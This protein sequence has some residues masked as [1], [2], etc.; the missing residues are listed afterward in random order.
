MEAFLI[1]RARRHWQVLSTVFLGVL[2]STGLLASC[3]LIVKTVMDFAL[4]HKLRSSL[5]ENGTIF[6]NSSQNTDL[7]TY[8]EFD[9]NIKEILSLNV[10][11]FSEQI[12]TIGTPWV[13]PWQDEIQ[14]VDERI[15][16]R[17]YGE[18]EDQISFISGNWPEDVIVK[19]N[20]IRAVIFE[21]MANT[22]GLEIG[23]RLPVS[24]KF[25]EVQPSI[26]IEVSGIVQPKNA[27]DPYWIIRSNPLKPN[28]NPRYIA[29]HNALLTERDLFEV[30]SSLFPNS[31]L[32][33]NWLAVLDPN[34]IQSE[35]VTGIITGVS[36]A[37]T[38]IASLENRVTIDT[39]IENYL[40][41]FNSQASSVRAP[42]YLLVGEVLFLAL[43]Y[44]IMVAA[45]S[46]RQVEGEFSILASRGASISQL[47]RVQV[48]EAFLICFVAL[49][50]GP[51][52]AYALVWFLGKIGPISDVNQIDWIARLPDASWIAAVICVS[53]CF[54]ALM[55]P[56]IPALKSSVVEHRRSITR[57]TDIPLWQRYYIDV[58][59][60]V[61]GLVALWRLSLYGSI[62]E[63][64][65]GGIDWLLL[66]A[67]LAL[68]IGSATILL[69]LFPVIFRILSKLTARSRGLTIPLAFWQTS[70]DPT[71][72][73][74]LILLFTLA[75]ALGILSTGLN[76][77]LNSSEKERARY[78]TGGEVRI[79][80][81]NFIPLSSIQSNS[82]V[83]SAS[84]V[85]RGNGSS[86]V[87]SYR[88][89]PGFTILAVDPFSFATVTQ[90]RTDF[91]E[92]YIGFVL[93]KLI[94]EPAQLPVTTIPLSGKPSRIGIWVTEPYPARTE[95]VLMDYLSIKAKIQSSEG[96][97]IKIDFTLEPLDDVFEDKSGE[98]LVPSIELPRWRYFE[99]ILPSFVE[100]GYPLSLHSLWFKIYP[101]SIDSGV[102][103]P[104]G[105]LVI[106]DMTT[107][108][109]Q[110]LSRTIEDFENPSNIWQT[111]DLQSVASITKRDITHS[112]LASMRL[113]LRTTGSTNWTVL[114]PA[115]TLRKE[116]I[117]VLSSSTFLEMTG[118]EVGD[119]F[120]ALTSGV[121]LLFK[122]RDKVNYFPTMYETGDRGYIITS[123]EAILAELNKNSRYPVNVNE[124]WFTVESHQ[125]I[126]ALLENYPQ[127][128]DSKDIESERILYKSNPLTLGLRSVIFLGYSLT[129]LLSLV[130][131]TTFFYLSARQRESIYGMLRSLGLSTKQLYASLVIEQLIL[132]IAGLALGVFLGAM[133]N[134][135]NLPGLPISF[136]DAPP[137][138]PFIPREDW[139]AVAQLGLILI[140]SFVLT[141]GIGTYLLWRTKLHQVLR[142]GEE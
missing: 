72:V 114:S 58:F 119:K 52:L 32:E 105:P 84:A 77:T 63:S 87:R 80:S 3:P 36:I 31:H 129:L 25:N 83:T 34:H 1:N 33:L 62:A 41:Q 6:L 124:T 138:P 85:W 50:C 57:R 64:V 106:D 47:F 38:K 9:K 26:W 140:C 107:I 42:L 117:P 69:R 21:S 86:N 8:K 82:N 79:I 132:V 101:V 113:L 7:E 56:V 142:V 12:S 115:Q 67:P 35:N 88:S 109:S 123:R 74:R 103:L 136:G 39:N 120:I 116:S 97:T 76:A 110:G 29:E 2:I 128:I 49:I 53:A 68:L 78:A 28:T 125:D 19:P 134:K 131:F 135:I 43:Y 18:I 4:P 37:R 60:L 44:V 30:V 55:I 108:D 14:L 122:I 10:R 73:T 92:D 24:L 15:N 93:G 90:Y 51:L 133:L 100:S 139:L 5:D 89:M 17:S 81:E 102:Y 22:Y 20:I 94:V 126:P 137:V 141:L 112:G 127:A 40:S 71:H 75:M 16:F 61:I 95:V 104:D 59:I 23:D 121:K 54:T 99:A 13:Y 27:Q 130:G 45:L 98:D 70:R 11:N 46:I 111:N 65:G 91:T 118:L 96:E 66:F 48:F